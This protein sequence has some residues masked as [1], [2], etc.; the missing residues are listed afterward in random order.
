MCPI[1]EIDAL[2]DDLAS[3]GI[4]CSDKEKVNSKDEFW[5]KILHKFVRNKERKVER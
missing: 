3:K 2:L 5:H 1:N 4:K